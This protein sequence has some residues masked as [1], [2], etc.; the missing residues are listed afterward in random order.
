MNSPSFL[1]QSIVVAL[2]LLLAPLAQFSLFAQAPPPGDYVPYDAMQLD[3]LVAPVALYPDALVAQ[4]LTAATFAGQVTDADNWLHQYGGMPPDQLADAVNGMPW[5]PSVKALTEFP[6]VLDNMA[7]NSSWSAA[8]GDAY[9][10]QPGDVM[11]A[12]QAMRYQAQQAGTLRN[13]PQQRVLYD[14]GL[15]VIEPVNPG[16]IYVPYY[17]PWAVY[18]APIGPWGGYYWGPQRGVV[19]G[20]GISIGFGAGIGIGLFTHYGWGYNAWAPNWRGGVVVYN[21]NTYIS[22]SPTVINQGR[23]GGY[24]RGVFEHPGRG[25]PAGQFHPPVTSQTAVFAHPGAAEAGRPPAAGAGRP[26]APESYRPAPGSA[27]RP[28]PAEANRPAPGSYRPETAQPNRPPAAAPQP[29]AQPNRPPAGSYRPDTAQPNRPPDTA[30]PNRPPAAAPQPAV[31]PY[32]PPA[33]APQP[34]VQP[35][36]P[37]AAAPQPAVQPN[38]P[39]AAAP[40]PA[41]QPYRPP[42]AAPQP[43]AQ[44]ARGPSQPPATA[45]PKPPAHEAP[46][47]GHQDK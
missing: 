43:A 15:V 6:T 1:R 29:A 16:L 41:V 2:A 17:D 46:K 24:N 9:Y 10:N 39:P 12:V 14:G 33:A 22:R 38:R 5:D 23:F 47:P 45:A 21:H 8:L 13:T 19:M 31:Q 26:G 40:Q 34:A 27:Y 42:A 44:P 30:Q 20:P 32:R 25:V 18:G 3:Q 28:A 4:V 37:P 7:R 35:Y 11:N 36:R